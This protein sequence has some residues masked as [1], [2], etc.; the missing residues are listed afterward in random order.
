M[1]SEWRARAILWEVLGDGMALL[2]PTYVNPCPHQIY[3]GILDDLGQ[4]HMTPGISTEV[5][6][7]L[8]LL[9][10]RYLGRKG[11]DISCSPLRIQE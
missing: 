10:V 11:R 6:T 3:L 7:F 2:S 5:V 9:S 1:S 4:C 8:R